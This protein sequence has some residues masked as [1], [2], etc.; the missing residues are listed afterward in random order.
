MRNAGGNVTMTRWPFALL[1][2]LAACGGGGEES[3]EPDVVP[4]TD[5]QAD[6]DTLMVAF[7]ESSLECLEA[8]VDPEDV[9]SADELSHER[10]LCIDVAKRTCDAVLVVDEG[11]YDGCLGDVETL[12]ADDCEAVRTALRDGTDVSMPASCLA[13][14]TTE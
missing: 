12:G 11:R 4:R 3:T 10:A 1:L 8:G 14:F 2:G 7:C 5:P 13:V 9:P 6:C